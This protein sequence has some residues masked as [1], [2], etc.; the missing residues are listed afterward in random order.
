MMVL[1]SDCGTLLGNLPVGLEDSKEFF[2]GDCG[3]VRME[4]IMSDT[5]L[6]LQTTDDVIFDIMR[7]NKGHYTY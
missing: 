6:D 7:T 5:N 1:C 2:C 4:N 3:L